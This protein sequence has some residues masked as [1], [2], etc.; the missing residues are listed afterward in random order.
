M[1]YEVS[2]TYNSES[3]EEMAPIMSV[4]LDQAQPF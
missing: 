2:R 1:P 3:L 4:S